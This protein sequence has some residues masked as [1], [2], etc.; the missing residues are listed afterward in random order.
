ML[1][2]PW[3][4]VL[5]RQRHR[6]RGAQVGEV[7]VILEQHVGD[8]GLGVEQQ[9]QPVAGGEAA[10]AI[11]VEAGGELQ[12]DVPA[13]RHARGFHV[14]FGRDLGE[15]EN[16][17]VGEPRGALAQGPEAAL[18]GRDGDGKGNLVPKRLEGDDPHV[19]SPSRRFRPRSVSASAACSSDSSLP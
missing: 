12:D 16:E 5:E 4:Q 10:L 18:D 15:L 14:H 8:A 1:G 11:P 9:E 6:G 2:V 7:P 3:R 13:A 17:R 19:Q